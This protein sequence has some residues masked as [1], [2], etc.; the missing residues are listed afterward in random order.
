ML[1]F[2][3]LEKYMEF[4][5][6]IGSFLL[7]AAIIVI[8][9]GF[10]IGLLAQAAQKQ[11][12]SKGDLQVTDLSKE[13]KELSEHLKLELMDKK[14]RKKAMKALKKKKPAD[15]KKRRLF[16]LDFKGSMDAKEVDNLRQEVNA[17][18][19]LATEKDE[20]LVRL[21]SGG[22]VV[23]GYGLAAAQLQRIKSKGLTLNVAID[24]VAAS[25]GYMMACVGHKLLAAPFSF[26]GS[27][28][29]VAQIPNFHRFLKKHDVD[30]EQLTAGEYKRTLTLFGENTDEGR[31]KFKQDL[32]AI[33]RQF[34]AFVQENRPELDIDKVATGEVWSGQEAKELGLVDEVT[35]SDSWLLEQ[36]K[37]FNVLQ[38]NYVVRK[39]MSER[40]AKGLSTVIQT[41]K[42]SLTRSDIAQ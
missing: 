37:T 23:N 1:A 4:L 30:F 18:L 19:Q 22:G 15:D 29:V 40:F 36:H 27:I 11:K 9:V 2:F 14:A 16:V 3:V 32:E 5:V 12:K 10:I 35:T 31:R 42:S 20:V 24:K 6:D 21:E 34:K 41:L 7:K 26:I 38:L 39:P 28:G 8:A 33:H 17:I 25:G 13:L